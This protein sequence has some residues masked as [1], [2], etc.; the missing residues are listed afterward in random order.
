MKRTTKHC[1]IYAAYGSNLNHEQMAVRCPN[2][3]FI[4]IGEIRDYQL[5]FRRVADIEYSRGLTVPVGLW[6]VTDECMDALDRYEGYPSLYERTIIQVETAA[7]EVLDAHVYFMQYEGYEPPS[8][9]YL[10]SIIDGYDHCGIDLQPLSD[11][12][13]LTSL[14]ANV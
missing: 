12:L 14:T 4:G 10:Q 11:A 5:V 2:A 13:D 8:A 6:R 1:S 7:G 3:Y 9:R